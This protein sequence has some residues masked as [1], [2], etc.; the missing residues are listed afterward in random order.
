[1]KVVLTAEILGQRVPVESRY[2]DTDAEA[3]LAAD[4]L[5]ELAK[6]QNFKNPNVHIQETRE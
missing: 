5:L 4:Q 1:V 3:Q 6:R 2:P